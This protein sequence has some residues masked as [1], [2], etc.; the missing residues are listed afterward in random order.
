MEVLISFPS[1]WPHGPTGSTAAC[2]TWKCLTPG[3]NLG[4]DDVMHVYI[5]QARYRHTCAHTEPAQLRSL[6]GVRTGRS[7][8]SAPGARRR[9]HA[10]TRTE[11]PAALERSEQRAPRSRP[12]RALAAVHTAD[13]EHWVDSLEGSEAATRVSCFLGPPEPSELEPLWVVPPAARTAGMPSRHA[14]TL[15]VAQAGLA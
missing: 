2:G 4:T 13:S 3:Q 5:W 11:R 1:H 12:C 6:A 10:G 7:R 9:W 14:G 8:S 15:V